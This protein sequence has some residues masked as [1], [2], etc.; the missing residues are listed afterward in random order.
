MSVLRTSTLCVPLIV[1]FSMTAPAATN[2]AFRVQLHWS[3]QAQFAG[4]YIAESRIAQGQ[5]AKTIEL[6]EGGPGI[7]VIDQLLNG[8]ADVAIG[9][10]TELIEARRKGAKVVNVAQV[11]RRPG[12]ALAFNK[13]AG[14]Q[15]PSDLIGRSVGVW[16]VGDEVS[17]RLWLQRA[18]IAKSSVQFLQQAPNAEDLISGKVPCATVM[19]YNEYWH[20]IKAGL[21]PNDILMVKFGDEGLGMLEDGIYVK[22]AS[23]DNAV[24]RRKLTRFVSATASGWKQA[25]EHQNEA[26]ALTMTKSPGLDRVHQRRMLNSILNLIPADKSFGVLDPAEFERS[27]D[28]FAE[29]ASDPAAIRRAAKGAWT[30]KICHEAGLGALA[31]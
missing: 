12:I 27:V 14:V 26:I 5:G 28:I 25:R 20:L 4:Y 7:D 29:H 3:H 30:H 19:V 15:K 2:M 23:L 21:N 11:F 24:F 1:L 8:K 22:E 18:G 10:F 6:L 31:K 16:N 9:W 13:A 17:V